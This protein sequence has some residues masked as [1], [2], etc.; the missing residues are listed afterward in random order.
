MSSSL[1]ALRLLCKSFGVG[2]AEV[3]QVAVV[4]HDFFEAGRF[5]GLFPELKLFFANG[6]SFPLL[7][8]AG[9]KLDGGRSDLLAFEE[10]V[11]A[12]PAA[13]VW[14]PINK[15]S[16]FVIITQ[17]YRRL[18]EK[19]QQDLCRRAPKQKFLNEFLDIG[20]FKGK[21]VEDQPSAEGGEQGGKMGKLRHC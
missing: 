16:G 1:K 2:G 12:P 21:G 3:D 13:E 9:K 8:V 20:G 15:S 14:A 19:M 7:L 18:L 17:D 11:G 4:A 6:P 10:R 5:D